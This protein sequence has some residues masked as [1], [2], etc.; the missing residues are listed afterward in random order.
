M[1]WLLKNSNI[2]IF[3]L[4]CL[5]I[6]NNYYKIIDNNRY[7]YKYI[8]EEEL[9]YYKKEY[10]ELLNS[11]KINE[12]NI[13]YTYSKVILHDIYNFYN[14]V[15]IAKGTDVG[16]KKGDLVLNDL[17]VIGTIKKVNKNSSIVSLLYSDNK[18]SIKVNDSYGVLEGE[19]NKL[20]VSNIINNDDIKIGDIIYTS[21]LSNTHEN[22]IIG[23]VKNI[24]YSKDELEIFLEVNPIVDFN[25][26]NYV[27]VVGE[28]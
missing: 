19:N 15:V 7:N 17:G 5:I 2:F 6:K 4:L 24:S 10:N 8:K 26:I 21:G 3:F 27:V 18:I 16:I 12:N 20:I 1:K 11:Y 25:N 13:N 14:E 22:F 23:N 9:N 28:S